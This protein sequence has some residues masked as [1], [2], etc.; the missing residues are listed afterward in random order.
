MRPTV[1]VTGGGGFIG[2]WVLRL[3]LERQHT[4]VALDRRFHADRAARILGPLA[5]QV[6]SY[7]VDLTDRQQLLSICQ[8]HR[9]TH[10]IHLAALLTPACQQDPWTG[11]QVNIMGSLALF[12]AA[13]QLREPLQGFSYAS[14]YAVYGP[15]VGDDPAVSSAVNSSSINRPPSFYGAFKLAVDLIAEQYWRHFQIASVGIRPH[16]VYGP[17]RDQGLTAGPSLA[18]R[19]AVEGR[20]YAIG[21][22]GRVAYDYVEDVA[23]AFVRGALETPRRSLV[24]DL[25]GELATCEEFAAAIHAEVPGSADLISVAGDEIPANIPPTPNY[26]HHLFPDWRVTSLREGVRRTADF[27]RAMS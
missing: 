7:E 9:V 20:P 18:T 21:Y 26:I 22:R 14:S 13:R 6:V 3:L 1:L 17:E 8:Q 27:Y 11:A 15:E 25:P 16:V 19:A 23:L 10:L 12:E 2:T 5:T 4:V 24:V